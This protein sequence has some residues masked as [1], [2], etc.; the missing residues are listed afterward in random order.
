[1]N[2]YSLTHALPSGAFHLNAIPLT[3]PELFLCSVCEDTGERWVWCPENGRD[4]V[5]CECLGG[6]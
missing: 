2:T 6:F 4:V 5:T 3:A 1:M